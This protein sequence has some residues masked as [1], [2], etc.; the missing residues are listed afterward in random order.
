MSFFISVRGG[1]FAVMVSDGRVDKVEDDW[2]AGENYSKVFR[3]N[4]K[5]CLGI[6]GELVPVYNAM[7]ELQTYDLQKVTME[8]I[9]RILINS[10]KNASSDG[11]GVKFV[12]SGCNKSG[13]FVTYCVDSKQ[14]FSEM[15]Q[16]ANG[17]GFYVVHAGSDAVGVQELVDKYIHST[18]PW[19][20]LEVLQEHMKDCVKAVAAID[21]TV[22]EK[23]YEVM[24][25]GEQSEKAE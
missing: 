23:T 12:L 2:I 25:V 19:E 15:M 10:L 11:T 5:V 22:N 21:D 18:A 16:V 6:T 14:D 4:E 17:S 9:K 20:N 7:N 24:V 13:K 8:R 3:L 1:N